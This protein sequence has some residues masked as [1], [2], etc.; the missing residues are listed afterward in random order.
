MKN[1]LSLFVLLSCLLRQELEGMR[2]WHR[3][4][5]PN[6]HTNSKSNSN[7]VTNSVTNQKSAI[8][9]AW[10]N[11]FNENELKASSQV[12]GKPNFP[13]N[14]DALSDEELEK[15]LMSGAFNEHEKSIQLQIQEPACNKRSNKELL[16]HTVDSKK[17]KLSVQEGKTTD[18]Q[19]RQVFQQQ[20]PENLVSLSVKAVLP[21]GLINFGASCY[22]NA[23]TQCLIRSDILL[24]AFLHA[25]E[26]YVMAENKKKF[27][28]A[29]EFI[30]L[31]ACLQRTTEKVIK[32]TELYN[33]VVKNRFN[34][35]RDQ[36]CAYDCLGFLID[37]LMYESFDKDNVFKKTL[38]CTVKK[39]V[40]CS[41]SNCM[42]K[43]ERTDPY[44]MFDLSIP[45]QNN[46]FPLHQTIKNFF[47]YETTNDWKC[48]VDNHKGSKNSYKLASVPEIFMVNLKRYKDSG[49]T[50]Y[51]GKIQVPIMEKI[52]TPI[53][54]PLEGL[55]LS[56]YLVQNNENEQASVLLY[57][58]VAMV[59]HHGE[60]SGGHYIN[61]VKNASLNE[62][63]Y[64]NDSLVKE[65][66]NDVVK[67]I[68]ETGV[69]YPEETKIKIIKNGFLPSIL[70]YKKRSV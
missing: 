4:S 53:L 9:N 68:A 25:K 2:R 7:S 37:E 61:F 49:K 38:M 8:Q 31:F 36:Q 60:M 35:S 5:R 55:D 14:S 18:E 1:L 32:P 15:M 64:C 39:E 57:D 43:S 30:E 45:D 27:P 19:S 56:Q 16:D 59:M 48:G 11:R 41:H 23:V 26:K 52:K 20:Q 47:D 62:W 44:T 29:V 65:K 58:L 10:N 67:N 3:K 63:V 34:N 12:N 51:Y 46:A 24:P 54:F 70:I 33:L 13:V 22:F 21:V 28:V 50:E 6:P 69:F 17:P 40:C 42:N 66:Y